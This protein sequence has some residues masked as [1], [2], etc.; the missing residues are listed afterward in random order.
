MAE[1]VLMSALSGKTSL[2]LRQIWGLSLRLSTQLIE[3]ITTETIIQ[4]IAV[5]LLVKNK[6]II[7]M[8]KKEFEN[9]S[10]GDLIR[11]LEPLA[12]GSLVAT[13]KGDHVTTVR[14]Q[15]IS[16]ENHD[17]WE[18]VKKAHYKGGESQ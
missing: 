16:A 6:Q 12:E 10:V 14:S 17:E 11:P 2:F 9:L 5:G 1:E 4:R 3:E 18:L 15:E 13:N 8:T 7:E